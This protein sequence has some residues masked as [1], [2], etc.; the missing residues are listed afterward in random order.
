M[1]PLDKR[2]PIMPPI[3]TNPVELREASLA[4][5]ARNPHD[6]RNRPSGLPRDPGRYHP[7]GTT[8]NELLEREHR[9]VSSV[10]TDEPVPPANQTDQPVHHAGRNGL[11][12]KQWTRSEEAM[13]WKGWAERDT[14]TVGE[15]A[16]R[17][18]ATVRATSFRLHHL[19][20][21]GWDEILARG[22][23]FERSPRQPRAT[24]DP[25]QPRYRGNRET[26]DCFS[27]EPRT[28]TQVSRKHLSRV[29]TLTGK[30]SNG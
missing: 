2:K 23:Q 4:A 1:K 30:I 22:G 21:A 6:P 26:R 17:V 8:I 27:P 12:L 14:V 13:L 7:T 18:E 20:I 9:H 28:A 11:G 25:S 16:N 10:G 3:P 5:R 24:E 19:L 29:R 15:L